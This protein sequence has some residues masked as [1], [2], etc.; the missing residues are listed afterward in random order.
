MVKGWFKPSSTD[1]GATNELKR[2]HVCQLKN[3][4]ELTDA[5]AAMKY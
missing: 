4:N 5:I 2:I 3:F 1:D